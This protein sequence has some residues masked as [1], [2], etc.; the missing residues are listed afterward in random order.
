[1]VE[2]GNNAEAFNMVDHGIPCHKLKKHG[3]GGKVGTWIHNFLSDRTQC[4]TANGTT[5]TISQNIGSVPGNSL[6]PNTISHSDR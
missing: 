1:M 5:S 3:I 2:Q 4:I 6:R